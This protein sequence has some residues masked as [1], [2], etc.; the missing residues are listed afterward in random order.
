MRPGG[1]FLP[2]LLGLLTCTQ[3]SAGE[4]DF[5]IPDE[6]EPELEFSGNLDGK[7]GILQRRDISPRYRLQF[8]DSPQDEILSQYRLDFYLNGSY[9][10]EQ[11]FLSFKSFSQY[12]QQDQP[13]LL[14][15]SSTAG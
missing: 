12:T 1:A 15:S 6:E 4:F 10:R 2:I 8:A 7:W 9:R 11:L 3:A 14:F 5:D 13:P